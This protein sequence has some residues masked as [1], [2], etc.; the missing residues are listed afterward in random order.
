MLGRT[1][2]CIA[3]THGKSTTTAMLGCVLTD[4]GL[5]PTVIV[6]ATSTQLLHGCLA[7]SDKNA[8][9][10]ATG[11]RLGAAAVRALEEGQHGM[12]VA[13]DPPHVKY[14]PLAEA[15]HRMR[16]VPL[17]SDIL[18]A[19]RDLGITFGESP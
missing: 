7:G 6:G 11:F 13:L 10:G 1:G 4:C 2:M 14:V 16:C 3:G 17:D 18:L 15:T 12:M 9:P 5:D 8:T 19:A